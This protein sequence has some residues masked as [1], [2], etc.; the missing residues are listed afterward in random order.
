M[1]KLKDSVTISDYDNKKT[2]ISKKIFQASLIIN[3]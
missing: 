2:D 1:L 3:K